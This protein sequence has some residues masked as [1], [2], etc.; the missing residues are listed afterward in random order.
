MS[1]TSNAFASD[2]LQGDLGTSF[3]A[4]ADRTGEL[5]ENEIK[6]AVTL[7]GLKDEKLEMFQRAIDAKKAEIGRG[8]ITFPD[9]FDIVAQVAESDGLAA[10]HNFMVWGLVKLFNRYERKFRK[11]QIMRKFEAN[12]SKTDR[13]QVYGKVS[14]KDTSI[15]IVD[16]EGLPLPGA[17]SSGGGEKEAQLADDDEL[18]DV[19][20]MIGR[21]LTGYVDAAGMAVIP[22][23]YIIIC[24]TFLAS[25]TEQL[26]GEATDG[27]TDRLAEIVHLNQNTSTYD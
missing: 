4:D 9:W 26:D 13:L 10:Y 23:V 15:P 16:D 5:D 19:S 3:S 8:T 24:L 14:E 20:D 17:H 2:D 7:T 12:R 27:N 25:K 1:A 18:A 6:R 22:I 11:E 21:K